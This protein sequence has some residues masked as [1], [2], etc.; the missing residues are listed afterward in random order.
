MI[1]AVRTRISDSLAETATAMVAS[2]LPRMQEAQ[3]GRKPRTVGNDDEPKRGKRL[4]PIIEGL[5]GR[6]PHT[7]ENWPESERRTWLSLI[8][9][10]FKV[11]YEDKPPAAPKPPKPPGTP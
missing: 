6:L 11:I 10:A 8:E 5:F 4:D 2:C 3:M 9:A 1:P 7:G